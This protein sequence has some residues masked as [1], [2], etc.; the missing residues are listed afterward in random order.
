M[1]DEIKKIKDK[2]ASY[3]KQ[4]K[5]L[6]ITIRFLKKFRTE[7]LYR[8]IWGYYES[9]PDFTTMVMRRLG[10]ENPDKVIYLIA[11][12][13]DPSLCVSGFFAIM[14]ATLNELRFADELGFVPVVELGENYCCYYDRELM[15]KI[16]NVFEYYFMPVSDVSC[17]SARRSSKVIYR[18]KGH[19]CFFTQ[20]GTG[21]N[22]YHLDE[23]EIELLGEL[24]RKY[25]HLNPDMKQYLEGEIKAILGNKKTLG[26]HFRGT[27]YNRR[28]KYHPVY[29]SVAE[30]FL[31][32]DDVFSRGDYEQVFLA[33]D[34]A[35]VLEQF[36]SR[37]GDQL[38]YYKD[39]SRSDNSVG[40]HSMENSRPMHHYLLGR[41]VVRDVYTLS[42]CEGLVCGLSQVSSAA[43][44]VNVAIAKQYKDVR[45]L[46]KG[47]WA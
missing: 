22:S 30:Y 37:Y 24:Y 9:S 34:D 23:E 47:T 13:D 14:K 38:V 39:S 27:D 32:V 44:Y 26:V 41:E 33:T 42:C 40:P 45:V 1:A 6:Y 3:I 29:I 21:E 7:G 46:N 25:I 17:A 10:D 4:N 12:D 36:K 5:Y 28:F 31:A 35:N 8:L 2:L 19:G 11:A 16:D 15:E 20:Y 43:R 18:R